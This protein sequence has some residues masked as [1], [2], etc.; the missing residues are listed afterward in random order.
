IHVAHW[1]VFVHAEN[2]SREAADIIIETTVK[3]QSG[4]PA[5]LVVRQE[6]LAPG[7]S[8]VLVSSETALPDLAAKSSGQASVRLT[9][10]QPRLWDVASPHLHV[11]RTTVLADGREV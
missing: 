2:V 11:M 6:M 9:V 10:G 5:R 8:T 3:N 4:Q 7:G 1:G